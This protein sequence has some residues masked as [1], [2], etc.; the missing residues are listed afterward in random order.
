LKARP[1]GVHVIAAAHIYSVVSNNNRYFSLTQIDTPPHFQVTTQ[2]LLLMVEQR[3][4][5]NVDM[6]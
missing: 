3:L 5:D 1:D 6:E 4:P 2:S